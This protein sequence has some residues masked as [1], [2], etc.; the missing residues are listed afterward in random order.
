M[1]HAHRLVRCGPG[2]LLRPYSEV[3]TG[4]D[5]V[6]VREM[7]VNWDRI[8]KLIYAD[9]IVPLVARV[10]RRRF[11]LDRSRLAGKRRDMPHHPLEPLLDRA[12]FAGLVSPCR[13]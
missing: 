7:S 8:D 11:A 10:V 2:L 6:G 13:S 12:E 4:L 9:R 5:V 1:V 3:R